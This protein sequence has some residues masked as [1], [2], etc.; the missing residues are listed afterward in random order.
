[1]K[2]Y[3]ILI[4]TLLSLAVQLQA[5]SN[6]LLSATDSNPRATKILDRISTDFESYKSMEAEFDLVISLPE[7]PDEVQKG[8]V[9]QQGDKYVVD[10]DQQAIYSD[11]TAVWLHLK[12]NNE[13]QIN[14]PDLGDATDM[15]S[16]KDMMRIYESGDYVYDITDEPTIEGK[17]MTQIDFK[18]L[19]PDSEYF[20][21]S[22][23]AEKINNKMAQMT[24]FSK[25]GSKYTLKI[26]NI[27]GNKDYDAGIF[28]FDTSKY[29]DIYIEDL[30]ID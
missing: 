15:L 3:T 21:I 2:H 5:Q 30:R 13:V 27:V 8:K 24:V 11:G 12:K 26:N 25:D 16:P 6:Q 10:L 17:K 14:D 28:R 4:A 18:P 22:L 23:L 7:Q 9:I 29:P 20:K 19:D 1:M